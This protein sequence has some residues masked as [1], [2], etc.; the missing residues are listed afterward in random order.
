MRY[1]VYVGEHKRAGLPVAS[2]GAPEIHTPADDEPGTMPFHVGKPPDIDGT[3][4][5]RGFP[6]RKL[7]ARDLAPLVEPTRNGGV[8]AGPSA[9]AR[10]AERAGSPLPARLPAKARR[11]QVRKGLI[12]DVETRPRL[13][14]RA[15]GSR[16]CR[17]TVAGA[18]RAS[19]PTRKSQ[20]FGSATGAAGPGR[21]AR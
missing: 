18:P 9:I 5:V 8:E 15:Q 2:G 16:E 13:E 17:L 6:P 21:A 14:K 4:R 19:Q 20:V 11:R 12:L 7:P 3:V 10:A 1:D